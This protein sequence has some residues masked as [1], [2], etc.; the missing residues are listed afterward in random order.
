LIAVSIVSHGHGAM[1]C[2]LVSQLL[3]Y[4]EVSRV[5]VTLNIPENLSISD[6]E[7]VEVIQNEFPM[8]FGANHNQAFQ[9]VTEVFFCPLNPDVSLLGNP[10]P[11]LVAVMEGSGAGICAPR[12]VSSKG[13][14][15]DSVRYFPTPVGLM[16]KAFHLSSGQVQFDAVSDVFC[17]DW[18][19]G[20]FMLFHRKAY[21]DLGG[22][23]EGFF[24]YYEDVDICIRAWRK[25]MKIVVCPSV[26]VVHDAQRDSHRSLR[27]LR[28]HL[29]S[30]VRYFWKHLGRLPRVD[31]VPR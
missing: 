24:L 18:V 4:P 27:H 15:E 29:A 23:D 5:I 30:I 17:P 19:A 20:M 14:I 2:R 16:A 26:A 9:R 6:G 12:V 28:W 10:F 22:F 25:G 31:R 1:V 8:G 7:R 3:E 11:Q 21:A 13:N